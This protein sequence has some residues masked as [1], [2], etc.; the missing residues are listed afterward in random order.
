MKDYEEK[1]SSD[2]LINNMKSALKSK[3]KATLLYFMSWCELLDMMYEIKVTDPE[4]GVYFQ[5]IGYDLY[6][7]AD[8][9]SLKDPH[10][11]NSTEEE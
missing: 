6:T 11:L 4:T 5:V 8:E 1:S 7:N 2:H 10:Q 9:E 3:Q